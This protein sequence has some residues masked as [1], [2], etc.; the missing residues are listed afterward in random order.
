MGRS[1]DIPIDQAFWA[2][3]GLLRRAALLGGGVTTN[4]PGGVTPLG[5]P[6]EKGKLT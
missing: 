5:T 1:P 3:N 4:E 6:I 2:T